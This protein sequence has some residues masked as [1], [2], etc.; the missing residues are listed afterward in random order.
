MGGV[1][2]IGYREVVTD[3]ATIEC[4]IYTL[5]IPSLLIRNAFKMKKTNKV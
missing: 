5:L 4:I 2:Q 3:V 1:G